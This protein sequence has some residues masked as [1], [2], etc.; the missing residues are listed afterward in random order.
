M[1][2]VASLPKVHLRVVSDSELRTLRACMKRHHYQ[3]RL[4]R[5]PIG[6][7]D[8]L[9][10]GSLWHI[11][12]EAWWQRAASWLKSDDNAASRLEAG[13]T[14]MRAQELYDPYALVTAEELLIAYTAR[15]HDQKIRVIDVEAKFEMP[16][17][18]PESGAASRTYRRGGKIDVIAVDDAGE[19]IIEHKTTSA[20]IE[21]GSSYLRKVRA[22]DTQV[23]T[24]L[25]GARALG[26]NPLRC[27]YDVVRKPGIRPL[28]A[29]PV[30]SRK[31]KQGTNILYANQREADETPEDFRIRLRAD[32]NERPAR[33]FARVDMIRLEQEER[34][35]AYDVWQLTKLMH[36]AERHN[37]APKNPD[38]CSQ[39][40]GCPYLPVCEGMASIDD[41]TLFR[42]AHTA[43]EELEDA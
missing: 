21:E 32:I 14:A 1:S 34:E 35:H 9:R 18:N 24:Y 33:Y 42:T 2:A 29:T 3:Y 10:F 23:S 4:L 25:A 19:C 11:G 6:K 43:H 38:A 27:V 40:G 12:Q 22:L 15:W 30:E 16:L 41:N 31:Y 7:T 17:V 39:F 28:K 20:D 8:A 5:R 37:F 36:E 26:H 13:L